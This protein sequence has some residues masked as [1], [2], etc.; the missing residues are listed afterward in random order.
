MKLLTLFLMSFSL[1][2]LSNAVTVQ[3]TGDLVPAGQIQCTPRYFAQG[4]IPNNPQPY[5]A[6]V[7][8]SSWQVTIR[9]R[10]SDGSVRFAYVC[11]S[12][13]EIAISGSLVVD[14]RNT[15]SF[16]HLGNQATC[17]AA[18]LDGA[19]MLAF[20]GGTWDAEMRVSADPVGATTQRTVNAR[21]MLTASRFT[22]WTRGPLVTAVI[23]EDASSS[24]VYDFGWLGSGCTAPY[25]T[26]T[27]ADDTTH[28]SLHPIFVL[29]FTQGVGVNIEYILAN[30]WT[31][32][33]QDQRYSLE[34]HTSAGTAVFTKTGIRGIAQTW[35]RKTFRDG[36]A[37][38][39]TNT[40][41][42]MEYMKYSKM[43]P[44]YRYPFG[45]I[46]ETAALGGQ[47]SINGALAGW[48]GNINDD[49]PFACT[50]TGVSCG[51][52]TRSYSATGGRGDRGFYPHWEALWLYTQRADL[53]NLVIG[54]A[55]YVTSQP[56]H[57]RELATG[58]ANYRGSTAAFGMPISL[59]TRPTTNINLYMYNTSNLPTAVGPI[60]GSQ[61]LWTGWA[62]DNAH[63]HTHTQLAYLVT[64][65]WF[66]MQEQSFLAHHLFFW[67]QQVAH[68]SGQRKGTWGFVRAEELNHRAV[69]WHTWNLWRASLI[70]PDA[71][72]QHGYVREKLE[73]AL[74]QH[75]GYYNITDGDYYEPCSTNP[76]DPTTDTSKWCHGFRVEGQ[77]SRNPNRH[78]TVIGSSAQRSGI[79]QTIV[80]TGSSPWMDTFVGLA[81]FDLCRGEGLA[82]ALAKHHAERYEKAVTDVGS[83][84]AILRQYHYP[85]RF[86]NSTTLTADIGANDTTIP[87]ANSAVC[88]SAPF[89][90]WVGET[91]LI[92]D[93]QG[94]NMIAGSTWRGGRGYNAS[95][96]GARTNGTTVS[97]TRPG[98]GYG[99]LVSAYTYALPSILIGQDTLMSDGGSYAEG[100]CAA[101]RWSSDFLTS[102]RASEVF[103]ANC[104]TNESVGITGIYSSYSDPRWLFDPDKPVHNLRA[105]VSAGVA[106]LRYV[107]PSGAACRVYVGASAPATSDDSADSTDTRKG[108]VHEFV[109]SSLSTGTYHYRVSC[110]T[111]RATGTFEVP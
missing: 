55:E 65:D 66:F 6:G 12:L 77:A 15:T 38:V 94:S 5:L 53:L 46:T 42:N 43:I 44:P 39:A 83:N 54:N 90:I 108:R 2:G 36:T 61:S 49:F 75:E 1:W 30:Y 4:E 8:S 72:P 64:G 27:W 13:T 110:G 79:D 24:R 41:F 7:A 97:C 82:C 10:W 85:V 48:S 56:H 71:D 47:T 99:E 105:T 17:E 11:Y 86:N 96:R 31:T 93:I 40:D 37:P 9:N 107:A 70:I 20:G 58:L 35:W 88:G 21:T 91:V 95:S 16:C 19:G 104:H 3:S 14:F 102:A 32:T 73:D 22:Y 63:R 68:Q 98:T 74:A 50:L 84:P 67:A 52:R 101:G 26:C 28:R 51:N 60:S 92:V 76:Y 111:A 29:T 18:G 80:S 34:L 109:V 62:A 106:T 33:R 45:P 87:V 89:T 78:S 57:L 59:N 81:Y 69:A 25:D 103:A 23:V 100:M